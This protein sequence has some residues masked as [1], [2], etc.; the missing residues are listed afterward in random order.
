MLPLR[1]TVLGIFSTRRSA[2]RSRLGNSRTFAGPTTLLVTVAFGVSALTVDAYE[3]VTHAAL[4][5]SA[6]LLSRLNP[7]TN[8]SPGNS[9]LLIR[10]G[11]DQR[12]SS[13]GVVYF[14][15]AR[16]GAEE[17]LSRPT[18]NPSFG[19]DKIEAANRNVVDPI[20]LPMLPAWLM[21]GAVR[22]DDVPLDAGEMENT[23]QDEPSGPFTRV[24]H[25]F[26]DPV[27]A[28]ALTVGREL[29]TTAREW[30]IRGNSEVYGTP[31]AF[32]AAMAREAMWRALTLKYSPARPFVDG[33]LFDVSFEETANIA[34]REAQRV[35]YWATTFRSL[36]DVVHLLQDMA[37]PQHT[38]NDPHGGMGCAWGQCSAGHK[39][40]YEGYV[41]AR[42]KGA[43]AF[44][45]RERFYS[46]WLKHDI[47]EKVEVAPLTFLGYP[48]VRL[49]S[50]DEFFAT[51]VGGNSTYGRGLAN[52]S[53][54]GFYSATTVPGTSFAA[55]YPSPPATPGSL[56][57]RRV[58]AGSLKNAAGI[59]IERGALSL[60]HGPVQDRLNVSGLEN[61]MPLASWGAF[62]QFL[63]PA[64]RRQVSLTHY[65][66]AEQARLLLPRAVAYS[67]GL[68]DYFFRGKLE[69]AL[70]DEGVYAARDNSTGVCNAPC[71][72]ELVKLKLTNDTPGE[73]MGPGVVV[74]VVKFHRNNCY[75]SD[76]SGEPG[77]PNFTGGS[78]RNP[79]EEIVVSNARAIASM[80]TGTTQ[81]IR[82]DF[83]QRPIPINATDITLQVVFR[84]KLGNEDDA[85]AVTTRNIAEPSYLALEN[86]TDYRYSTATQTYA[87][88]G[89]PV[90]FTNATVT[91]GAATKPLATLAEMRAPGHA[92]LA[93]LGDLA[94]TSVKIDVTAPQLSIGHPITVGLAGFEFHLPAGKGTTYTSNWPVG[95]VRGIYRRFIYG[96]SRAADY[97]VYLCS[98]DFNPLACT[99]AT[100]PPLTS[101]NAV[102]WT[103]DF[104]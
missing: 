7:G 63:N 95:P 26:Y 60:L 91:L 27:H 47:S 94:M 104:K 2:K 74:A 14:D 99:E 103:V 51:D 54:Q 9:D 33:P 40:Y 52:Y 66:Y 4:T 18:D 84:G 3:F 67:A 65:N 45:L 34:S 23:P 37:Q 29:G 80:A 10:L 58:A 46:T 92:Q 96:V 17:R 24:L 39:S 44:A 36:G 78:C 102:P 62:D 30:A 11:L 70:P 75:R 72:F 98:P 8:E 1:W 85:V 71:N 56:V 55:T 93:F 86:A 90:A 50:L 64:L 61:D 49:K 42:T 15:M 79:E 89:S 19:P 28:S 88:S 100:L 6:Y 13:L 21:L 22:E 31:N 69:I 73:A 81:T 97:E 41:E 20:V 87:P 53:N 5:R 35:A 82:F 101:A 16:G 43:N 68:L 77:G 38:R 12:V 83:S 48:V 59:P 76:L 25:H 57:E 32:S